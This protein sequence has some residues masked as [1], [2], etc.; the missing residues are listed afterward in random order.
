MIIFCLSIVL[1][2]SE[3]FI[4]EGGENSLKDFI[5]GMSFYDLTLFFRLHLGSGLI[6]L[7][8]V[9]ALVHFGLDENSFTHFRFK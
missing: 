4:V 2:A 9:C 1:L 7:G 6:V 8:S 3:C 5:F